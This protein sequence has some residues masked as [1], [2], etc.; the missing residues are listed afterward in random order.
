MS[1]LFCGIKITLVL[2]EIGIGA[3]IFILLSKVCIPFLYILYNTFSCID[4]NIVVSGFGTEKQADGTTI[5]YWIVRNSWVSSFH[6]CLLPF[7]KSNLLKNCL[8]K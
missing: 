3:F 4:H 2:K 8:F 6:L 7:F 1:H 5:D